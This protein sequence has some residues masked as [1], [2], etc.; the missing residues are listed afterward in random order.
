VGV[1][2]GGNRKYFLVRSDRAGCAWEE[3][4]VS[5]FCKTKLP[6]IARHCFT[7]EKGA[8]KKN[9]ERKKKNNTSLY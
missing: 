8:F 7:G 1:G 2:G 5:V 6:I 3:R 9:K 4:C